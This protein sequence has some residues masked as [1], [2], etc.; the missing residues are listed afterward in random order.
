MRLILYFCF[1]INSFLKT[2]TLHARLT[3]IFISLL[4]NANINSQF[5]IIITIINFTDFSLLRLFPRNLYTVT[6]ACFNY[7]KRHS[8]QA[9]PRA[10]PS[11]G[12][13]QGQPFFPQHKTRHNKQT[14]L[15]TGS[16]WGPTSL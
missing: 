7:N 13:A 11:S 9:P 6:N 12:T 4:H 10:N 8:S 5:I 1:P 15:K 2:V 16:F 3:S 14:S